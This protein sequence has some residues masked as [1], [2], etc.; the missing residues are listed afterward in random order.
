MNVVKDVL[1]TDIVSTKNF[2]KELQRAG[3]G[4][5]GEEVEGFVIEL[6]TLKRTRGL[7][8]LLATKLEINSDFYGPL[9]IRQAL[10]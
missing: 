1:R 7:W 10:P 3:E 4:V 5:M 2:R 8:Q 6:K 9:V